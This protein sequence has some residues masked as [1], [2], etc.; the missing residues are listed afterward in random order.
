MNDDSHGLSVARLAG[1]PS[2]AHDLAHETKLR[3]QQQEARPA[4]AKA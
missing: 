4:S 1:M 2:R 3:L